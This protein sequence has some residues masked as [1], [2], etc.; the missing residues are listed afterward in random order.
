MDKPFL[1]LAWGLVAAAVLG[2][3]GVYVLP[4]VGW[5][6]ATV[7]EAFG[8]AAGLAVAT[9]TTGLA[10]A[11]VLAPWVAEVAAVTLGATGM[12]VGYLVVLKVVEKGK[13]HPYELLV[14]VFGI[15]AALCVDLTKDALL[16]SQ[17]MK[18]F[19]PFFT[20]ALTII[21]GVLLINKQLPMRIVG[22]LLPFIPPLLVVQQLLTRKKYDV[23]KAALQDPTTPEF[24]A[25]WGTLIVGLV[26]VI[27]GVLQPGRGKAD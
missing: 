25:V 26:I 15:L 5:A 17:I 3:F 27:I 2:V 12:G 22:G 11:T 19:Y 13:D 20:G 18:A 9:A 14:P 23:A 21:G 8:V 16:E 24:I 10:T 1:V 7:I 4:A 6:I